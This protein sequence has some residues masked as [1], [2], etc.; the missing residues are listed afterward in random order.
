MRSRRSLH[1]CQ[2]MINSLRAFVKPSFNAYSKL[3]Q[4][5]AVSVKKLERK[6]ATQ[7][8]ASE[9]NVYIELYN[10]VP[11]NRCNKSLQV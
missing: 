6:K 3:I 1:L 11:I 9:K 7:K 4:M 2:N 8:K 5:F 10:C